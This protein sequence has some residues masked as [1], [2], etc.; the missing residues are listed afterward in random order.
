[1]SLL[2]L[3]KM[4]LL[5]CWTCLWTGA[6]LY[7]AGSSHPPER[8][9]STV[10]VVEKWYDGDTATITLKLQCKVRLLDCWAPE[11]RGEERPQGL[12]S[13]SHIQRLVPEGSEVRLF[14]PATGSL[15][16]S[17]TFGRIL[18]SMWA[19]NEDGSFT[20]VSDQMVKDGFA[21]RTKVKK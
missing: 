7:A 15:E 12:K 13:K 11:V 1:M 18:G 14:I 9:I 6:C 19:Q 21:T 10:A 17:L 16:D 3:K 8:G 4:C 5:L 2:S 20:N